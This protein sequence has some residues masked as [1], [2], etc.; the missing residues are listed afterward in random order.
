MRSATRRVFSNLDVRELG[1]SRIMLSSPSSR[2]VKNATFL[3]QIILDRYGHLSSTLI[4][5]S[6]R[7]GQSFLK[8]NQ[9]DGTI[10]GAAINRR[11]R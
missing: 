9:V 1:L 11:T 4:F 8:A 5:F 7:G 6:C 10:S 3:A 2:G